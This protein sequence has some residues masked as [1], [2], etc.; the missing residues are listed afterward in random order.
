M[1]AGGSD[2]KLL[3]PLTDAD[4]FSS[5]YIQVQHYRTKGEDDSLPQLGKTGYFAI[6][7]EKTGLTV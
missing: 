7:D 3:P 1:M 4:N 5:S 2:V 6:Y